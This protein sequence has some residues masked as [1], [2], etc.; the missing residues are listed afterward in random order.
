MDSFITTFHIDWKIIIAQAVNFVIVLAVLYY[1]ALKP[2]KK[3]MSERENRIAGG[4]EDAKRNALMLEKTQKEYDAIVAKARVEAHDIFQAG[5][6][7]AEAK[8]AE[9]IG[10]AQADVAHMIESGK[11][12]LETEKVK[13]VEEAKKE[14]VSLVVKATEKLLED[15]DDES[16]DDKQVKKINKS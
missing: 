12:S 11:K 10:A 7:E 16:F 4:L 13:M 2:L 1:F 9:M 15:H 5:K 8:K 14:I 6:K 3:L